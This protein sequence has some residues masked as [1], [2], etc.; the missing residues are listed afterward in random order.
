MTRYSKPVWQ[1]VQEAAQQLGEFTAKEA[2]DFIKSR[3]H[4]DD[5]N[6]LTIGAQVIACSIDHPSAHHYPDKQRFL[7]YLGNGR[8]RMATGEE[9][10]KSAPLFPQPSNGQEAL[11]SSGGDYFAQIRNGIVRIPGTVLKKLSLK[12]NDF[13]AF[14]EDDKGNVFLKK[15]ELKVV[16]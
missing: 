4:E 6:E 2:K 8:F 15:A 5:V 7:K 3:Y 12:E 10:E 16:G 9:K 14:V 1:M 11:V 13:L